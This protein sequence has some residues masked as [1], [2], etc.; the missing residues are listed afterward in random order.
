VLGVPLAAAL[1]VTVAAVLLG[2]L[3]RGGGSAGT[4]GT[5]QLTPAEGRTKGAAT[6]P[7]T[8]VEYADMQCPVC[9]RFAGTVEPQLDAKYIATGRVRLEVRHFA[10]LGKESVRA[11][12]AVECAG[13]QGKFFEYRDM[14]YR[15]QA[16]E[17]RGAFSDSK[18]RAMAAKVGLD[19]NALGACLDSGRYHDRVVQ[20]TDEGRRLGVTG[21]PT[22]FVNGTMLVGLQSLEA[23]E[24]AI[25]Q[26][27]G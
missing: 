17:N 3:T 19:G 24:A 20:D 4:A 12:E 22:F 9:A 14:V 21:T 16:G 6:A 1:A 5:P 13:E 26:A 10:F 18:L 8:I 2:N 7:V 15:S 11:A 25:Q 23:L 27:G